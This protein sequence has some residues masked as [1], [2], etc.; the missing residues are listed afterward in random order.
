MF[1][2]LRRCAE[3]LNLIKYQNMQDVRAKF[4]SA[5][6]LAQ[7]FDLDY[8]LVA[9]GTRNSSSEGQAA[10]FSQIWS[11]EY[12]MVARVAETNDIEEPCLG[13]TFHYT[14]DESEFEGHVESW[15]DDDLRCD[16][17]RVRRDT[18]E[19]RIMVECGHLLSNITA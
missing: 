19:S 12:A 15:Y 5:S 14:E 11:S 1:R 6:V 16:K 8:V 9:G 4:I 17:Y 2:N 18:D 7:V 3:I 13:R 10:V